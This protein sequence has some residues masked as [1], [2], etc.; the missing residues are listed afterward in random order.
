MDCIT[1]HKRGAEILTDYCAGT[2]DP[3]LAAQIDAHTRE[4]ADCK[5]VVEAQRSVWQMLDTWAPVKVSNDFDSRL[6]ARIAAEN[7]APAWRRWVSRLLQPA[8]PYALWKPAASLAV[9]GAIVSLLVIA[10]VPRQ[11]GPEQKSV[12]QVV[13]QPSAETA[14]VPV[15]SKSTVKSGKAEEIDLQQLQ[16]ALD[17]LDVV[18]PGNAA[19]S[20]L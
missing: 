12:A 1:K 5:R 4:C 10:R 8:S 18:A 17:D 7:A 20:P 2:L 14:A 6:Y 19:L 15:A 11:Q 3:A 16:Q 13:V 9:A